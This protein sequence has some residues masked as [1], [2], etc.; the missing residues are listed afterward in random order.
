[1]EK[2]STANIKYLLEPSSVAIIGASHHK[3]KIGY[4]IL[5]NILANNYQGKVYP[6][7]QHGGQILNLHVYRKIT[8]IAEEVNVAYIVIPARDV[9]QAVKD[10]AEKKVK[11]VV[12]ISS[13]FAEIGKFKEERE[14]VNYAH[15]Q[16]MRVLGPNIFGLYSAKASFNGTFGPKDIKKGKAAIITQSGALGIA[17]M[18]KTQTKRIGLSAIV[19]TGNKADITEAD[20]LEYFSSDQNTK[21]I[22]IYIEGV[23]QGERF[24]QAL[25]RASKHKA[26]II[27]RSGISKKGATAAASH[28]AS[29]AGEKEVFFSLIKQQGAIRAETLN[30]AVNWLKFL[31]DAPS[32]RGGQAVIITNGGGIGVLATDA[33]E[34]YGVKLLANLTVLKKTFADITPEFGSVKNPIDIT[35]QATN[36]EYEKA[37]EAAIKEKSIHSII[38][39]G[40]ETAL[41]DTDQLVPLLHKAF[42]EARQTKPIVF[43]FLGGENIEKVIF[44]LQKQNVPIFSNV[45][46]AISCLGAAHFNYYSKKQHQGANFKKPVIDFAAINQI[47]NKVKRVGRSNL[48]PEETEKIMKIIGIKTPRSYLALN[49]NEAVDKAEK[50]GYPVVMAIVSGDIIHKTEAGGVL[51]NLKDKNEVLRGYRVIMRRCRQSYPRA[52]IEGIE[53][54]KM[55]RKGG[56]ETII[57]ARRDKLFGPVVAF[58]LGGILV[59]TIKDVVFR[60]FPIDNQEALAMIREIKAASLFLGTRKEKKK[61]VDEIV[62][63]IIKL[64]F[65]IQKCRSISDIEINPLIVYEQGQGIKALDTKII[66]G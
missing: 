8:D 9:F 3:D 22:F 65:I 25:R 59:E 42:I 32:L 54:T 55:I 53:V 14:I 46:E 29:L 15:K 23:K 16:G 61:D 18:G 19:S 17:L 57:G 5:A 52:R 10:C 41:L 63:T 13:G 66:L 51:L 48:F 28:T 38:C 39:L 6:V 56:I 62:K 21:V 1:M 45:N 26:V 11:F 36:L 40:C 43:S 27:L 35:G 60:T 7:N 24:I 33:C 58:G 2:K 44:R 64:G 34:K 49:E 12:I 31:A 47:I 37:L 30:E 4:K 50:I 20:L